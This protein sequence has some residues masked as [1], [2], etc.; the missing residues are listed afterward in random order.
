MPGSWA[1][2]SSWSQP[3]RVLNRWMT[4][5][6]VFQRRQACQTKQ[7]IWGNEKTQ[8]GARCLLPQYLNRWSQLL[9]P[10]QSL[11]PILWRGLGAKHTCKCYSGSYICTFYYHAFNSFAL[12]KVGLIWIRFMLINNN[13]YNNFYSARSQTIWKRIIQ[14]LHT[15]IS[16]WQK[17]SEHKHIHMYFFIILLF[18]WRAF[19]IYYYKN[20][21]SWL[22]MLIQQD[23]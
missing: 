14:L 3:V 18:R 8:A 21:N 2:L 7:T 15:A 20:I 10:I 6:G 23:L 17:C 12:V 22:I 11:Y 16:N 1:N 13:N 9:I 19:N 5:V 4:S